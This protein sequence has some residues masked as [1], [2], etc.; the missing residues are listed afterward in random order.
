MRSTKAWRRVVVASVVAAVSGAGL[1]L[2]W[3]HQR[4][5]AA[6]AD[7]TRIA[8]ELAVQQAHFEVVRAEVAEGASRALEPSV[9]PPTASTNPA[10][11]LDEL[12]QMRVRRGPLGVAELGAV[13]SHLRGLRAAGAAAVPTIREYLAKFEDLEYPTDL[14][15]GSETPPEPPEATAKPDRRGSVGEPLARGDRLRFEFQTPPS[16]RVGLLGMTG[17]VP[18]SIRNWRMPFES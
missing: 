9:P 1:W 4:N 16:L 7:A 14:E 17:C 8:R 6:R 11:L 18:R 5:L 12:Q 13:V 2:Q 15:Y 3:R 10:K